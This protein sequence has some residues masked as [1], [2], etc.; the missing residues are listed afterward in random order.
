MAWPEYPKER[1]QA[2]YG[3][4]NWGLSSGIRGVMGKYWLGEELPD[5][6][7]WEKHIEDTWGV[8][9][10]EIK[11][12]DEN[13]TNYAPWN[14]WLVL[15]YL[16]VTGQI[17][18]LR[19][20]DEL[21]YM[22]ERYLYEIAPS[23]ARPHYGD[24]NGWHDSVPVW[25]YIFERVGQVVG[26][27]RYKQQSRLMWE[28]S[29][30]HVVNWRQ[31]HLVYDQAVTMLTRLL[32]EVPDDSLPAQ[33]LA[34]EPILT[35]RGAT[36]MLS[37]EERAARNQ[38]IEMTA[39][40]VPNKLIF[41]SSNDPGSMWAMVELNNDAGHFAALP[42]ALNCLM[43]K[44]T[45][46]LA[47]Q[48][49]YEK[50]PQFH[51]IVFIED[52]EGTQGVQP[53]MDIQV[54]I[55]E[56]YGLLTYAV[57]EVQRFMR[58]PVTLRRHFVF[59]KDRF[60]WVRD[61]LNFQSSFFARIGPSWLSRQMFSSGENWINTYFD[62]MPYTG[63]GQGSGMHYWKNYNYDLLTYFVPRA[64]M[65]LGL[66]D[67]TSH[68]LYMNAPLRVRQTWRGLAREGQ[69]LFFDAVLLP[70]PVVYQKPDA[71]ALA[72]TFVLLA[73]DPDQAAVEF[74]LPWRQEK[75]LVVMGGRPFSG[76][77][78]ETDAKLAVIVWKQGEVSEWFVHN[79][80]MLKVADAVLVQSPTPV[81]QGR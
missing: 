21:R 37:P 11:D 76:G 47:S 68:N 74:E 2:W 48:G 17:D 75:A 40:R 39:E 65:Q 26:D 56:D 71:R 7:L 73:A 34:P 16:D 35:L 45:V 80:K 60:M 57:A 28:Y 72:E 69:K 79:A 20:D 63:L 13:T 61:E 62:F 58:W 53:E 25:M 55:L 29:L 32:A 4:N 70:H 49:Y 78:V 8:F 52:L 38:W 41:R 43:D 27:G 18:L 66:T 77:G 30:R 67:L 3:M 46:L 44:E 12:H 22:F 59:V 10:H 36:H 9:L 54:P 81:T 6:E 33:P 23:G 31:Y 14:L 42:T 51:N 5:T 15:F 19:T 64:G 1:T 50:D 24:T